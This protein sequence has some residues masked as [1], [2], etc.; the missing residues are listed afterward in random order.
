MKKLASKSRS[1]AYEK[2]MKRETRSL[3]LASFSI[4]LLRD[5]DREILSLSRHEAL[6]GPLFRLSLP[7]PSTDQCSS[8]QFSNNTISNGSSYKFDNFLS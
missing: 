8:T 3:S 7:R 5:K 1:C 6:S 4:S 2:G